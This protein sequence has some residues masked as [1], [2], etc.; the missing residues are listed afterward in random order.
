MPDTPDSAGA[1]HDAETAETVLAFDFGL[2]RIGVAVG[3]AVTRSATA[4]TTLPAVAG[5]PDEGALARLI[6]DWQPDRLLLG[7]PLAPGETSALEEPLK[8]F[9]RR[10]ERF[11]IPLELVDEQLSSAE[12][13]SRLT[14]E[15][16]SGSRR[17]RV[18]KADID[19][20]SARIIAEQW[21]AG[22]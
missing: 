17:R 8:R 3:Q 18:S 20:L 12:A 6:G 22:Q 10:L 2:R 9:R 21:L 5:E 1:A 16:R 4:L 7:M 11:G 19:S 15:R 13:Q 14:G